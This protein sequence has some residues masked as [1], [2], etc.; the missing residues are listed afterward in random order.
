MA[1]WRVAEMRVACAEITARV[2]TT[3]AVNGGRWAG[4]HQ[5]GV[6]LYPSFVELQGRLATS[7]SVEVEVGMAGTGRQE[8]S[9]WRHVESLEM[10]EVCLETRSSTASALCN[11]RMSSYGSHV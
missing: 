5:H 3:L 7:A 9:F 6:E 11:G 8:A 10:A 1:R 4:R 2:R